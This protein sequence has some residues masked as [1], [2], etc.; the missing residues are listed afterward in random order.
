MYIM[1]KR[2]VTLLLLLLASVQLAPAALAA[3]DPDK[4]IRAAL[5]K[6]LPGVPVDEIT[7]SPLA[8]VSEVIIGSKLFYVSNDGKY[9]MQ[10]S[11]IEMATRTNLSERRLDSIRLA[12]IKDL[13]ASNM[14]VFPAAEQRHVVTVFTDID[15]GYCRKLHAEIDQYNALGITVRYMMYPRS[16]PDTPSY[17]K[18]VSVWCSKDRQQALT[19]SKAGET[20]PKGSCDN[21]VRAHYSTGQQLGIRGT[22]AILLENGE[23]LPGYLPAAKLANEIEKRS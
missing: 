7:P 10:G 6:I 8:G 4:Q 22:P 5:G 11:L 16:G 17:D 21:P 9:L 23:L 14:I 13:K 1:N 20:L 2:I 12:V 3:D 19:R 15:C 18:A